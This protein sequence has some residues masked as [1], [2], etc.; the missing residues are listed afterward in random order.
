MPKLDPN[1]AEFREAA[2]RAVDWIADYFEG[3][4]SYPVL[5][6]VQ[7]GDVERQF[8]EGPSRDGHS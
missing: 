3:I 5:S 6:R 7:P 1:T 8:G 2:H 4:D